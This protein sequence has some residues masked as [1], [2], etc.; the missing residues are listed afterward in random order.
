MSTSSFSLGFPLK[1]GQ[2]AG[3]GGDH[4]R[5]VGG[6]HLGVPFP[7]LWDPSEAEGHSGLAGQG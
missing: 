6:S 2:F 7:K 1:E 4:S 5:P 3:R